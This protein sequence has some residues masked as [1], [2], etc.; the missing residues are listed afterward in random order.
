MP[1]TGKKEHVRDVFL[2]GL[3]LPCKKLSSEE[4]ADELVKSANTLKIYTI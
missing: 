4:I 3:P 1:L 2:I